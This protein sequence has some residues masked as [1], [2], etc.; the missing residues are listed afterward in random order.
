M[1]INKPQSKIR[2]LKTGFTLIELLVVVAIIAVLI[3]ILLPSLQ[4][5]REQARTTVCLANERQMGTAYFLYANNYNG[6]LP[7]H[8]D[9][10]WSDLIY[11]SSIWDNTTKKWLGLGLFF[12]EK[13]LSDGHIFYCPSGMGEV[14]YNYYK[15]Q[16]TATPPWWSSILI[17]YADYSYEPGW[18]SKKID[19]VSDRPLLAD[20]ITWAPLYSHVTGCNVMLGDGS[21]SWRSYGKTVFDKVGTASWTTLVDC[22]LIWTNVFT[23]KN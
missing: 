4:K 8:I 21:A 2:G 5:A 11:R 18:V 23:R 20:S 10:Y 17:H 7:S 22:R 13:L 6:M 15:T 16:W 19:D 1:R 12:S 14:T 3:S 9:N